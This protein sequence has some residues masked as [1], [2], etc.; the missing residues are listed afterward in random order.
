MLH[1]YCPGYARP[2]GGV[3]LVKGGGRHQ[4][5]A[6]RLA[7]TQKRNRNV[8]A[9]AEFAVYVPW[10]DAGSSCQRVSNLSS[11][12]DRPVFAV[13]S[14]GIEAIAGAFMP[15]RMRR[16]DKSWHGAQVAEAKGITAAMGDG[17][18]ALY[19]D[20]KPKLRILCVSI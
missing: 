16:Q 14:A 15:I 9:K 17:S 18:R 11:T 10:V 20:R 1:L 5:Y 8:L 3:P 12:A 13:R 4:T 7:R 19:T 2:A 6:P